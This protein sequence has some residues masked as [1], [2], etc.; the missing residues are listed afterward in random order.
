MTFDELMACYHV[1]DSINNRTVY[2][3][4]L[5][6]A[7]DN[8]ITPIIGAGL[9]RW[10]GYPGW[11][12]LLKEQSEGFEI[13]EAIEELLK[14]NEYEDAASLLEKET[15]RNEFRRVLERVFSEGK[16]AANKA[17]RP[18]CHALLP[19]L[20]RGPIVTT[21]F[22]RAIEDL[23]PNIPVV[24]PS[25]DFQADHI[26]SA[27]HDRKPILVKMHGDI[28]DST[29]LVFTTE[30]YNRT[31]GK[32][33]ENPD[34]TLPMPAFLANILRR[35]PALFLGCSLDPDRTCAVIRACAETNRQ[36]ALLPLPDETKNEA[37]PLQPILRGADGKLLPALR[38]RRG[39]L[40]D[41]NIRPIWYPKGMAGEALAALLGQLARDM[42]INNPPPGGSFDDSRYR[43]LR[44]LVGRD[45]L[46]ADIASALTKPGPGCVWVHG[47]AGVGK[48]E[49]CKAVYAAV[50]E[51][52][53]SFIMPFIDATGADDLP[54]FFGRVARDADTP[55]PGDIGVDRAPGYLAGALRERYPGGSLYIDNFED[56]WN[57][58]DRNE[59]DTLVKWLLGLMQ[60]GLTLLISSR[61]ADPPAL[62]ASRFDVTCL[63]CVTREEAG[64]MRPEDFDTLDSARLF[65]DILE[66]APAADERD[67]F[68]ELVANTEGHPLTIVLV[69]TQG[70]Y[71]INLR[72]LLA[73]WDEASQETAGQNPRHE[74][75]DVALRLSWRALS[76]CEAAKIQW[77]LHA[78]SV[79][80]IPA[81]TL[82]ALRGDI[83]ERA[84]EDGTRRLRRLR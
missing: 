8:N 7:R 54:A 50:R 27:M 24:N 47:P 84:W 74:S 83:P 9:S 18:A 45:D 70:R 10:A 32:D 1:N 63:R 28:R 17:S 78:L 16:I 52:A 5:S 39:E 40:D 36:F 77:G 59:R 58:S 34:L 60:A 82:A 81:D 31:Y 53:S 14:E 66:R 6:A 71:E 29:H 73:R 33:A 43:L 30:A 2:D 80:P 64:R 76:D 62:N 21:N 3:D 23:V 57:G 68:V 46:I 55:L 19:R 48:T 4:L 37:A 67:A 20:F 69:A 56:V 51:K 79:G 42:G 72:R 13:K 26:Q 65:L 25:D 49:L 12:D 44:A 22:D 15:G 61:E 75:L 11:D 38:E 41:M 35:N